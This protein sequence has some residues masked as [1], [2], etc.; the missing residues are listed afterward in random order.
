MRHNI[1]AMNTSQSAR[2][3]TLIELA[4]VILIGGLIMSGLLNLLNTGIANKQTSIQQE[5]F[6][7]IK[8]NAILQAINS[9]TVTSVCA[10]SGCTGL[11]NTLDCTIPLGSCRMLVSTYTVP[12]TVDDVKD[13]WGN[14]IVYAR[15]TNTITSTT[16]PATIMFTITSRGA[17]TIPS[18]DDTTYSV[19]AGE[20]MA[21]VSRMGF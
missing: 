14:T 10:G 15:V 16:P 3:F 6:D 5:A 4:I 12:A 18:A 20:F 13:F 9:K 2:G 7:T 11:L 1:R 17:D 21:R 19:N 8:T